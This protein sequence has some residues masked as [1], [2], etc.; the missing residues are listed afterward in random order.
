M[1]AGRADAG[2]R[3]RGHD[4]L[5]DRNVEYVRRLEAMGKPVELVEFPGQE[6]GFFMLQPWSKAVDELIRAFK[7]FMDKACSN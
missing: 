5:R 4:S 7:L 6:H 3:R 2:H 1:L